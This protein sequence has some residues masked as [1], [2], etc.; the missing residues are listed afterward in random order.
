MQDPRDGSG[1]GRIGLWTHSP[2]KESHPD[3]PAACLDSHPALAQWERAEV[4]ELQAGCAEQ[5]ICSIPVSPCA[6][7]KHTAPLNPKGLIP[8]SK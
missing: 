1:R 8:G 5:G 3:I 4:S 7:Q 2:D 6:L